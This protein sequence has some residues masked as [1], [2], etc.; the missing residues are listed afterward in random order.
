M[1]REEAKQNVFLHTGM[2]A[3][4]HYSSGFVDGV[5]ILRTDVINFIN[6]IFDEHEVELKQAY[7]NGSNS[8]NELIQSLYRQIEALKDN[9]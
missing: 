7:I 2:D 1:T 3:I 5:W 4:E 9:K 6:Q 8:T